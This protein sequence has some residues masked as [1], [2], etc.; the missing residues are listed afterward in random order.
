[1]FVSEE[2]DAK[3]KSY[4]LDM[5]PYPS[6]TGLHVGHIKGYIATDTLSR[7]KRMQGFSVLHPMGWDAFGLPA[8]NYAIKTKTHP[9]AKTAENIAYYKSQLK[10]VGTDHDWEREV[11]TTD[12]AYYKW[13]QWAFI[14]M[15]EKG[16]AYE[17]YEPINWCPSCLTGLANE[18]LDGDACE[19]CGTKV[20]QKPM[21]QWVLAIT[22]YADRLLTGLDDLRWAEHIKNLQRNWIG[23]SEGYVAE[24]K[25][26]DSEKTIKIFTTRLDTLYGAT[27]VV[28]AP[29]NKLVEELAS[30]ISNIAEV[31]AYASGVGAKKEAE[32]VSADKAKAGIQ[33]VGVT[34]VNPVNGEKVPVFIAEYVLG[35]YGTGAVMAV[36]AHDTRDM[37]FAREHGLPVRFVIDAKEGKYLVVEKSLPATQYNEMCKRWNCV[38]EKTDEDWGK[39]TRVTVDTQNE[40]EFLVFLKANLLTE[41]EDGGSWYAD[42]M[43]STN[44]AVFNGKA[45]KIDSTITLEDY[46]TYGRSRAIPEEQL[47]IKFEAFTEDGILYNSG[48]MS[49]MES[50]EARDAIAKKIGAAE[51]ITYKLKDWVFSRQRYWGEPIPMIHCPKCGVVAVPENELP[52]VL[53]EVQ[54]YEPSGTGE[55]PLAKIESWVNTKCPKCGEASKRETNTMPQW[56]GSCWYYLRYLDVHNNDALV[57]KDKDKYWMPVDVYVGGAEHATRHLIYARFWHKFL[58]DIGVVGSEEPFTELHSVGLILGEDGRKMSKRW[59]NVINPDVVVNQVGADTLRVFEMFMGPFENECAWSTGG[60]AGSRRF[61]ERVWDL[62]PKVGGEENQ[63]TITLLHKTIKQVTSD[64]TNFSFNTAVSALMILTNKLSDNEKISSNAYLTLLK[65]L[66]PFAPHVAEELWE[67]MGEKGLIAESAWPTHDEK[68]L[69]SATVSVVIQINSKVRGRIDLDPETTE[70]MAINKAISSVDISKWIEG[71]TISKV[72]YVKGRLVNILLS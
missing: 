65:L 33:L 31:R 10:L 39:F 38:V 41:S 8:E 60:I 4:V 7:M 21:R 23:R 12:P 42:S 52:L 44:Y 13:T 70:E 27:H 54:S 59:N 68:L 53:P 62:R 2:N 34:A 26:V 24:F 64:I 3:K 17:S 63:S 49:G 50:A 56:A 61:I 55:S 66:A 47:D 5:F 46:K 45:F 6:G 48:E 43:N 36:P 1:M 19:R 16:L 37:E 32:R 20:E 9:A 14:K 11:D 18:D 30:N 69:R 51:K 67:E 29:E 71:K 57:G 35:H 25:I 28:L 15:W 40:Q 58:F 72:I 22:K